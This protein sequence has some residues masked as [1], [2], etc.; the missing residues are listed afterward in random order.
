MTARAVPAVPVAD[1][2][3]ARDTPGAFTIDPEGTVFTY[4]CPCGCR[5][6]GTLRL[7]PAPSPSW[8]WDG[9]RDRPT[10]VPSI[11]DLVGDGAGGWR[12][13]WHGWLTAGQFRAC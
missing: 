5:C 10:L 1:I 9:D 11:H 3:A 8:A 6:S 7:R 13:H 12:T 4:V 2:E